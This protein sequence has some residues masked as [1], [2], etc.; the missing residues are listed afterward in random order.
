MKKNMDMGPETNDCTR[1][2][3]VPQCSEVD[4]SDSE[5]LWII[6]TERKFIAWYT[7]FDTRKTAQYASTGWRG[8]EGGDYVMTST[9]QH[10]TMRGSHVN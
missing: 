7:I 6:A 1:R 3:A 8:M 10:S 4:V 5:Q 9:A 2:P